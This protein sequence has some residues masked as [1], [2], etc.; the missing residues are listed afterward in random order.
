L[1]AARR[2]GTEADAVLGAVPRL[3]FVPTTV[4]EAAEAVRECARDRLSLVFVGGGTDLG[5]GAPPSRLDAVLRTGGM[6]RVVEHAP[7][8]QIVSVEAGLPLSRLQRTLAGHGQRLALDPPFPDRATA[9]GVVAAS[10]FGP[11]RTR[12]G[13][14]RDLVIGITIVRADGTVARGGG[15]VVKNVAGFDLPRLMVGSL[16]TLGLVATVNFRLHPLP[17]A[18]A[19]LLFPG[20]GADAVR[21]L[22]VAARS[23]QLEPAAATALSDGHALDLG[24][25]FEG[26]APGVKQQGDRLLDLAGKAGLAAERLDEPGAR[27]F[28]ERHAR[29]REAGAF[30]ARLSAPPSAL[31]AVARDAVAPLLAA[32]EGGG[33]ALYPTLGLGFVRGA[34][35]SGPSAAAAVERARA[36]LRA[37]GGSLVLAAAPPEVRAAADAWGPPPAALALMRSLKDRLDPERRLAPGRFAGGL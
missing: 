26:F 29:L 20:L 27:A 11:L 21:S 19:T 22:L 6:A 12:Y 23:A 13:G 5:L 36:A 35:A 15:K 2:P 4:E 30:R 8:D 28:W 9:G 25:R 17:E 10:A 3:V 18:Q 31:P 32:L 34:Q 37:L 1:T 14:V 7:S 16:G 33:A 24:V